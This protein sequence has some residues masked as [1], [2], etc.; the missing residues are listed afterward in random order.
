MVNSNKKSD[1][2]F[3]FSIFLNIRRIELENIILK[4]R[5]ILITDWI[6]FK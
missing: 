6:T 5:Q 4:L 3:F 2:F 1:N